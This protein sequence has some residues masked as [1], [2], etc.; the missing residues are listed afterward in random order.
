[1][2]SDNRWLAK[3]F[4]LNQ[5]G[6]WDDQ[7]TGF[8]QIKN[9]ETTGNIAIFVQKES[10]NSLILQTPV[11]TDDIYQ[12]QDN[13]I[14]WCENGQHSALSFEK[15]EG[16]NQIWGK[17]MEFQGRTI[18]KYEDYEAIIANVNL[19]DPKVGNLQEIYDQILKAQSKEEKDGICWKVLNN[20]CQYLKKLLQVFDE[21]ED[22]ENNLQLVLLAKL[23]KVLLMLNEPKLF[24]V[25][26]SDEF[27]LDIAGVFE[28]DPNLKKKGQLRSTLGNVTFKKIVPIHD[29]ELEAKIKQNFR[30]TVLKD[31]MLRPMMDDG[32]LITLNSMAF[33]N[34]TDILMKLEQNNDYLNSVFTFF[35]NCNQT[36]NE[37]R[38]NVLKFLKELMRTTKICQAQVR[39]NFLN[40][41]A[42]QFPFF[43]SFVPIF[44]DMNSIVVERMC[45]AE[46][47]NIF[48]QYDPSKFRSYVLQ[49]DDHPP[50]PT[51][52]TSNL[53]SFDKCKCLLFWVIRR[54]G[55]DDD[56]GVLIQLHDIIR[57]LLDVEFMEQNEKDQFL[58]IFYDH[59][60]AWLAEP[61]G[62]T[63]IECL[64][65][66]PNHSQQLHHLHHH[67]H[68]HAHH[69]DQ[70]HKQQ[71]DKETAEKNSSTS[72][73]TE[74]DKK[75]DVNNVNLKTL[76]SELIAT[77]KSSLVFICELLTYFV[78]AHTYRFKYFSIRNN[79]FVRVNSLFDFNDPHMSL[80]AIGFLR[81]CIGVKDD[82]Y[83]R[84][85]IQHNLFDPII[86]ILQKNHQK[87]NLINSSIYEMIEFIRTEN[88]KLLIEHL[89]E[90]YR[91]V[92]EELG[93]AKMVTTFEDLI[94]KYDQNQEFKANK[95]RPFGSEKRNAEDNRKKQFLEQ[96][97]DEAYFDESDN[98]NENLN[99]SLGLVDYDGDNDDNQ[100]RSIEKG[101]NIQKRNNSDEDDETPFIHPHKKRRFG[102]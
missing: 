38:E 19:A 33:T 51:Q 86:H 77:K 91:D 71:E 4:M 73:S 42:T 49:C 48:T 30:I 23:M 74:N 14:S 94:R 37:D 87:D 54:I 57:N 35:A 6:E 83:N 63:C 58:G 20:N 85:I 93:K 55:F 79:I 44:A 92:L 26:L 28:Y 78:K 75:H 95:S 3:F 27:F 90:K 76:S 100:S 39:T 81:S 53:D 16:C 25:V 101:E 65:S 61:L 43:S 7:G 41:I 17:I 47:L 80:V 56:L 40:F 32:A 29:K 15:E 60:I 50:P 21:L 84:H 99:G 1:M 66:T 12:K 36:H 64:L 24:E 46:S 31:M 52:N 89:V 8:A 82:F 13:I 69:H 18:T 96:A 68:N 70:I 102:N 10:D 45:A 62:T 22:L 88:L 11:S 72:D 98:E 34:N 97:E 67:D 59:Y 5:H 9:V 2:A